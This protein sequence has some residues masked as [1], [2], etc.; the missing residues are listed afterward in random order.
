MFS[1]RVDSPFRQHLSRSSL[2]FLLVLDPLLHTPRISSPNHHHL[3]AAYAHTITAYSSVIPMLCHLFLISISWY[4]CRATSQCVEMLRICPLVEQEKTS[5]QIT[6][7]NEL[8]DQKRHKD[9][10]IATERVPG[11]M[12]TTNGAR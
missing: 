7:S 12:T 9:S 3:F 6:L 10:L 11:I 2:V 1:L 5:C 8:T 4:D